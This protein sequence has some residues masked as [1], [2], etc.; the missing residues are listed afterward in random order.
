MAAAPKH[1]DAIVAAAVKLFR[2][3]GY[4]ATGLSEILAVSG[5]PKGSLYHY[6]PG[7]KVAI[8]V[9][10]IRAATETV[11]RTLEELTA[12]ARHP[13]DVP[14]RYFEL[15]AGWL[16]DSDFRDGS[17]IATIL[18]ETAS[19]HEEIRIAGQEAYARWR[20]LLQR[21][22]TERGVEAERAQRIAGLIM[23]AVEGA[24]LQVRVARDTA[25]LAEAGE[26]IARLIDQAVRG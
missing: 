18:L 11:A 13:G 19:E 3:Q 9:A 4:A 2:E 20:G 26:E 6:F 1:R 7:G 25:P 10:A 12:E 24:L 21:S 23:A 5:A 8:G 16:A 22:M 15:T 14:R 17:P